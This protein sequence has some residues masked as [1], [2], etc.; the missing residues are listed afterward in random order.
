MLS[1]EIKQHIAHAVNASSAALSFTATGGGSI[2]NAY[3]VYSNNKSS[4]FCKLNSS[5][6]F[7]DLFNKE[8]NG[9]D[10][11]SKA[12]II[13]TPKVVL[14]D[15]VGDTEL[16]LMEL[17]QAGQRTNTFWKQFGEQLAVLHRVT[18]REFGFDED[19]Y[20]GSLHQSNNKAPD[21][22]SFFINERLEPQIELGSRNM[23]LQNKH[24]DQFHRMYNRLA[25]I[26]PVEPP[27]LLHGD[28][29]SGNFLCDS[30]HQP[31][32]IDPAVYF[33]NRN[34][35]LAM[36]TLFGGFDRTFYEAYN[37]HFAFGPNYN[38]QWELC[39]LYPLLVHLNLF[40]SNYLGS[41]SS[42]ISRF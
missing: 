35:D 24:I 10:A 30:E 8:K 38:E 42:I 1:N 21:W 11:I 33:G 37:H 7:P 26:F 40:G 18:E 16:I 28:L 12:K 6:R 34:M 32:L 41:I 13:R 14:V 19:N 15:K 5:S 4:F 23:L 17:I 25:S 3:I 31:V 39:N 20:I 36:T 29:W 27:S 22:I 2:S 9:L